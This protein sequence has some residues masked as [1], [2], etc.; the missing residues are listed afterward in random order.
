MTCAKAR[1]TARIVQPDGTTYAGENACDNPQATCPRIA[2]KHGRGVYHLCKSICWQ[3]GHA[4]MVALRKA[5]AAGADLSRAWVYVTHWR[6]CDACRTA[7]NA[8]GISDDRIVCE[9]E[10]E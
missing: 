6:I 8:C 10:K 7:L 2:A 5:I 1:V 3:W 9:G 4:E